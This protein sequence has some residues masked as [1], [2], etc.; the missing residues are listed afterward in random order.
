MIV[1]YSFI[2]KLPEYIK[3]TLFQ[4]RIFYD[5]LVYLIYDDYNSNLINEITNKYNV[6]LIKY[7]S[8]NSENLDKLKAHYSNFK[9]VKALKD[10]K[11]LFYRSFERLYLLYNLI[12][13]IN[14]TDILFFELDILIYTNPKL[15]INKITN[16]FGLLY[17][18]RNRMSI[19]AS[20]FRNKRIIKKIITYFDNEYLSSNPSFPNEMTALSGFYINNKDR[21]FVLPSYPTLK[22]TPEINENFNKF[23]SL[24]D[25]SSYGIF[26]LGYDNTTHGK[27]KYKINRWGIIKDLTIENVVWKTENGLRKPYFIHNN[28][29]YLLNNLHVHSKNLME[30][31]S[32]KYY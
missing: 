24:F 12:N 23:E 4:L 2:G 20:F 25:P 1:V 21:C 17:D 7:S 22:Y 29:Y 26:L 14:K 10:R 27:N 15:W 6:K 31:L 13:K 30:G 32:K 3:Y 16:D 11:L 28:N 5:G 18:N 19:G 8:V 9:I